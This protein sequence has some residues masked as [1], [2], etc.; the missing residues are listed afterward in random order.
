[1]ADLDVRRG[2]GLVARPDQPLIGLIQQENGRE[3]V[4]YFTDERQADASI[5]DDAVQDALD[6]AGAWSDL[7]W[8]DLEAGLE[9]I[10]R[11]SRPTPPIGL[12]E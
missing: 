12:D 4:R 6:L 2:P 9:G 3:V 5:A 10:R 11:E 8:E 1:M 7:D